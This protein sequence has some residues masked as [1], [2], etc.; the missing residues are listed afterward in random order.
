MYLKSLDHLTP[1]LQF[2]QMA[3][4]WAL[5]LTLWEEPSWIIPGDVDSPR[6]PPLEGNLTVAVAERSWR[7]GR[8]GDPSV[9]EGAFWSRVLERLRRWRLHFRIHPKGVSWVHPFHPYV[10]PKWPSL[11]I[12]L[13]F[14]QKQQRTLRRMWTLGSHRPGL[15]SQ[16]ASLLLYILWQIF[17]VME[18]PFPPL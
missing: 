16:L 2:L 9:H 18:P 11:G 14:K 5:E 1:W 4:S 7:F 13:L 8:L 10:E 6:V 3:S 15:H 12:S 17:N